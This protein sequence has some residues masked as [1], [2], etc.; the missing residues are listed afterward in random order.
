VQRRTA[1]RSARSSEKPARWAISRKVGS[2]RR[3][4]CST[5]SRRTP[6]T[7]ASYVVPHS[8]SRRRSVRSLAECRRACSAK[9]GTAGRLWAIEISSTSRSSCW[10]RRAASCPSSNSRIEAKVTGSRPGIA[11]AADAGLSTKRLR[12][13]P[14][15]TGQRNS[16]PN[17]PAS[18]G[19]SNVNSTRRGANASPTVR[20]V[21]RRTLANASRIRKIATA[22]SSAG[23][24]RSA[25]ST[26]PSSSGAAD[27]T[28]I[29]PDRF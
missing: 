20:R 6:S 4:S 25:R 24:G 3:S 29:A 15:L 23:S 12:P 8:A 21:S 1:R 7:T 26:N 10:S 19:A 14:K 17:A 9:D 28:S 16:S 2:G 18:D 11:V 5:R 22:G 13:A 27:H